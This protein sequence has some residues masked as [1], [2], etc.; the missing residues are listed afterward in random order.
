MS[1][2]SWVTRCLFA[3]LASAFFLPAAYAQNNYTN[4]GTDVSTDFTLSY[5][6]NSTAQTPITSSTTS[7][8]V[9]R[10]V[11]LTVSYQANSD[12]ANVVPG[13]QDEE[14]VFLLRN[15]GNDNFAYDLTAVNAG[16]GDDFDGSNLEIGYYVDDGDGVYEPGADDGVSATTF[17]SAT[18]DLAPDRIIWVELIA[19]IPADR[20]NADTALITLVAD[21]LYPTTW[22]EEGATGGSAGTEVLADDGTNIVGSTAENIL[23]DG[24]GTAL[25]L[26][27]AGDHSSVGTFTVAAADLVPSLS[28]S[29][30]STNADGSFDCV[31]GTLVSANE[32]PIPG[33]CVEYV[34]SVQNTGSISADITT[35]SNTLPDEFQFEAATFANFVGGTPSAPANGTDCAGGACTVSQTGGAIASSTTATITIRASLN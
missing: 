9:D 24:A 20:V 26:D 16:S 1:R 18:G 29:T 7:F 10:L 2:S 12:D 22:L 32:Y 6:L 17:A 35:L 11:D 21:T 14:L 4:A 30:I 8:T 23:N 34:I 5:S 13:A 28:V 33:A 15:D 25:E 31:N 19:D 3:A 27:N